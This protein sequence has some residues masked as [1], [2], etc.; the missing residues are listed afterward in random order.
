MGETQGGEVPA[1]D[2]GGHAADGRGGGD[3]VIHTGGEELHLG[4]VG[5]A[6]VAHGCARGRLPAGG[7]GYP[8]RRKFSHSL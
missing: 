1:R 7:V 2:L 6:L 5:A 4:A 3:I 8:G